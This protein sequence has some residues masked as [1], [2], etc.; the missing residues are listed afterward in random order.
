MAKL[1]TMWKPPVVTGRGCHT[2][3]DVPRLCR[4]ARFGRSERRTQETSFMSMARR[5]GVAHRMTR[6]R[7]SGAEPEYRG[8]AMKPEKIQPSTRRK[9]G[10]QRIRSDQS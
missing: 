8:E 2:V 3:T 9:P 7:Q 10:G 1:P 4:I 5:S 6:T